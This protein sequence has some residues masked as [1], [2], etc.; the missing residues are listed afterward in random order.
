MSTL[1]CL[2]L[3][4]IWFL[5]F[6]IDALTGLGAFMRT[7]CLC[8]SVLRVASGPGV[9]LAGC[10]G[11]LCPPP[12]PTWFVLLTVLGRWS[13]CLPCSL[14]LCG[15]FYE[16]ICFMS[17]LVLFC[18]CVFRSFWHCGYLAGCRVWG[19][20]GGGGAGGLS[21]CFSCD[22]SACVCIVLSAAGLKHHGCYTFGLP[23]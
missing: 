2:S 16:A 8:I 23:L 11:A 17:Y 18:S 20:G 21:R 6:S 13:R 14:L 7:E 22:C 10:G 9:R 5:C 15:L 12:T 3:W 1:L 19:A 4:F